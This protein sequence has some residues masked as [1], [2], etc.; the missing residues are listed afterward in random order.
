MNEHKNQGSAGESLGG[1][2]TRA[3]RA[4]RG[5]LLAQVPDLGGYV[6][7][8]L[9]EQSRRCGKPGCRCATGELHGPYVYLSV[10]Q[11]AGR[12]G[13]IYVP[14]ALAD[15]VA[16]KVAVSASVRQVLGEISAINLEL[17][18]RRELE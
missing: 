3:L 6:A 8:S 2:S 10:G 5:R 14:A 17:L 12:R 18:A 1:V 16:E 15:L 11:A 9:V 7:G 4:R 13:L